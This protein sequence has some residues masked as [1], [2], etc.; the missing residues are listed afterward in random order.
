MRNFSRSLTIMII[1]ILVFTGCSGQKKEVGSVTVSI[2]CDTA[3]AN[4]MHLEEK[5]QGI[6]PEDGCILSET[7][8]TLYEGDTVFWRIE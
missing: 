5:W 2:H 8:I 1:C 4:D 7:P 6:L 3:I